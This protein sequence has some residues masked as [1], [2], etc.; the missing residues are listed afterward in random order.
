MFC[1]PL[2]VFQEIS[3]RKGDF[4]YF[5]VEI[6]V[7]HIAAKI[8]GRSFSVQIVILNNFGV[9][10]GISQFCR[11]IFV[12]VSKSS[13]GGPLVVFKIRFFALFVLVG[14]RI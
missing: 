9:V 10:K 12:S 11:K 3:L 7:S 4:H 5:S 6:F 8:V 2:G 13:V 1:V 14:S